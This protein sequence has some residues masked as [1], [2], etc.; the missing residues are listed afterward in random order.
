[1]SDPIVLVRWRDAKT[2]PPANKE[3]GYPTDMGIGYIHPVNG[4]WIDQA[5]LVPFSPQP[6]VWCDPLPPGD[7][8]LTI[9]D[10][11]AVCDGLEAFANDYHF[12]DEL[13]GFIRL[14]RAIEN[15][16]AQDGE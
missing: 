10:L 16:E 9:D 11:R 14:R 5:Y 4:L 13:S 7:D 15:L 3:T 2:D 1:M 12:G 6:F 8:A